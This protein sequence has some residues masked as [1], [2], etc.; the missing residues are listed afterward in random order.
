MFK[1]TCALFFNYAPDCSCHKSVTFPK[2]RQHKKTSEI[3][4]LRSTWTN[5]TPRKPVRLYWTRKPVRLYYSSHSE[6]LEHLVVFLLL[7]RI[8]DKVYQLQCWKILI[9]LLQGGSLFLL[10]P[11]S[12]K[13]NWYVLTF[14]TLAYL[15]ISI[16]LLPFSSNSTV[17]VAFNAISQAKLDL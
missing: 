17:D 1:L 11:N 3:I 15:L 9:F 8:N 12:C 10:W 6:Q 2:D 14:S 7:L 13:I 5:L 4:L 16:S